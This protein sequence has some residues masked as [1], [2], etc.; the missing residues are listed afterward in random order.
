M[1]MEKI[2]KYAKYMKVAIVVIVMAFTGVLYCCN[3]KTNSDSLQL[4]ILETDSEYAGYP[5]TVA[6]DLN[7]TDGES[8]RADV[9][10]YVYV[11]GCV[12]NPGVYEAYENMR[13]YQVIEMAGGMTENANRDY[14]NIAETVTDGQKLYVPEKS[15]I[16]AETTGRQIA[17]SAESEKVDINSAT[18]E[19]LMTLPGIGE[20]R[21][22]D[23]LAYK[24]ANGRFLSIEEIK[25]VSGI[26]DAAFN[27]IKELIVAK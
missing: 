26:K 16:I 8:T 10:I 5:V 15:E 2:R 17:G 1:Q 4:Q 7:F 22:N 19:Q 25:N 20:S 13:V 11:C 6:E 3:F 23:I 24:A 9:R 21:A 18:K 14:L 27:R 12:V